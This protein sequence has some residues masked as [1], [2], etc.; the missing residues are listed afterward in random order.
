[1][2]TF[3]DV[4]RISADLPDVTLGV[5]WGTGTWKVGDKVF[6]W[7]R[8]FSKA[9]IKRFGTDTP[10]AGPILA[11]STD[12][13]DDKQAVLD[14]QHD[15]VFTIS[16]FDGYAALL[17]QLDVVAMTVLHDLLVDAWM[18]SAPRKIVAQYLAANPLT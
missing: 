17:I 7:E 9:D 6:A 10:P 14:E 18:A 16:H 8:P 11:V 1:M 5:R 4:T 2:A 13:L 15:G 12:G 3:D